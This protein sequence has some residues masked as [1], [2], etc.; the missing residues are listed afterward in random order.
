VPTNFCK[1]EASMKFIRL[2]LMVTCLAFACQ[3]A[4]AAALAEKP[5]EV[6]PSKSQVLP[7]GRP[8]DPLLPSCPITPAPVAKPGVPAKQPVSDPLPKPPKLSGTDA[9]TYIFA[10]RG[11]SLLR[12]T[13]NKGTCVS[14]PG[15]TQI[16]LESK[17]GSWDS[18]CPY[19]VVIVLHNDNQYMVLHA[20]GQLSNDL[21]PKMKRHLELM[22]VTVPVTVSWKTGDRGDHEA[23]AYYICING[24]CN[25]PA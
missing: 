15:A 24:I 4:C 13:V 20:S 16:K 22:Q 6:D 10:P 12:M 1:N 17:P 7:V 23:Y 18:N 8:V 14:K 9:H 5:G 3:A 11:W 21:V 19:D 2:F 25:I